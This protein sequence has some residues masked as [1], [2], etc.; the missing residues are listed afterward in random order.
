[1]NGHSS[2]AQPAVI[3]ML[4]GTWQV[5]LVLSKGITL[6]LA[7]LLRDGVLPGAL[8]QM[9]GPIFLRFLP[10]RHSIS[11]HFTVL[12]MRHA[13]KRTAAVVERMGGVT[14]GLPSLQ[15]STLKL[16]RLC[17]VFFCFFSTTLSSV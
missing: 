17:S 6:Y 15:V 16:L 3:T 8:S 5:I 1:M 13:H 4:V 11:Q 2:T 12:L 7:C 9:K 14:A 10:L